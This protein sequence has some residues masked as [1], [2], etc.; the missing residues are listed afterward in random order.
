MLAVHLEK[1]LRE[2]LVLVVP[3][4]EEWS[5]H[6]HYCYLLIMFDPNTNYCTAIYAMSDITLNVLF[7]VC[8]CPFWSTCI[9]LPNAVHTN[10]ISANHCLLIHI[11]LSNIIYWHFVPIQTGL[12]FVFVFF[13][14]CLDPSSIWIGLRPLIPR[15]V[16][17]YAQNIW[18]SLTMPYQKDCSVL[19][20]FIVRRMNKD[21]SNVYL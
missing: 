7:Q 19:N 14:I 20:W 8:L 15:T 9:L 5:V 1:C 13:N 2:H 6:I 12:I 10:K 3:D 4:N 17:N 16:P 11:M 18:N 21:S